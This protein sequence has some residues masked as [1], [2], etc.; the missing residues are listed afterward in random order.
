VSDGQMMEFD[1]VGPPDRG[2]RR[3]EAV[4]AHKTGALFGGAMAIGTWLSPDGAIEAHVAR[5][6]GQLFGVAY[7][8]VDDLHDLDL[9]GT[10]TGR[11]GS[12]LAAGLVTQPWAIAFS[13]QLLDVARTEL[14]DTRA[15]T[16]TELRAKELWSS[17]CVHVASLRAQELL[18]RASSQATETLP[19]PAAAAFVNLCKAV[20]ASAD[21]LIR[22]NGT[23][24]S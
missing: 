16:S 21:D 23:P 7:Q 11:A 14:A 6:L 4:A 17:G 9:E 8:L 18:D 2:P 20:R 5:K 13:Q 15:V 1:D 22:R 12:D 24:R 10:G 19:S 3:I